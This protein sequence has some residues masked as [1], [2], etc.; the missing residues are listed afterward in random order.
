ME[1]K[2]TEKVKKLPEIKYLQ[3]LK[4]CCPPNV[5]LVDYICCYTCSFCAEPCVYGL[6]LQQN[7]RKHMKRTN[8]ESCKEDWCKYLYCCQSDCLYDFCF[9]CV[10]TPACIQSRCGHR[11]GEAA[12]EVVDAQIAGDLRSK[13]IQDALREAGDT[14]NDNN[15]LT[16]YM[17]LRTGLWYCVPC[18]N[19]AYVIEKHKA[20]IEREEMKQRE[21]KQGEEGGGDG[22]DMPPGRR[23]IEFLIP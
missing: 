20:N 12:F 17:A 18:N 19:I 22:A 23:E 5:Y 13:L 9:P 21:I 14:R 10:I 7:H 3:D 4:P 15:L 2:I 1:A 6:M 16:R 8:V 11:D